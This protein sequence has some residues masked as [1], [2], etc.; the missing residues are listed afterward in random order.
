MPVIHD[1]WL[2][3]FVLFVART[4]MAYQFQTVAAIGPL[5]VEAW[6]IDFTLLGTLIGLYMLPGVIFALPGGL[7]GQRFGAKRVVLIGLALMAG[8]GALM[9]TDSFL[10]AVAGR[11]ISGIGAVLINVLM[12]KMVTDWFAG[13]EI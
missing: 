11:V 10:L 6:R 7:L 5:L 2:M 9:A 12:T 8:G 4:E 13:R 3:L 1:R